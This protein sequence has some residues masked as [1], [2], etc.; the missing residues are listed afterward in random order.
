MSPIA[1]FVVLI[2]ILFNTSDATIK[3]QEKEKLIEIADE[4]LKEFLNFYNRE[5]WEFLQKDD[6]TG[7]E[8]Y[9]L[10]NMDDIF[11]V[12][13]LDET[14]SLHYQIFVPK[15]APFPLPPR[16]FISVQR[17]HITETENKVIV[18]LAAKSVDVN[19]KQFDIPPNNGQWLKRGEILA[20]TGMRIEGNPKNSTTKVVWIL[21]QDMHFNYPASI[22]FA[23]KIYMQY[24]MIMNQDE[25]I[26]RVR[27]LS[28]ER[29][30]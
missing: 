19:E 4:A 29:E 16:E 13:N 10:D 25:L 6:P 9:G 8:V 12:E 5:D 18:T 21:N 14:T 28:K 15:G 26:Q 11:K 2:S 24:S 17:A 1:L 22:K 20:G 3:G 27:K 7:I 23:I 30:S